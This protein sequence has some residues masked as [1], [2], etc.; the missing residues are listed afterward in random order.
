MAKVGSTKT[1]TEILETAGAMSSDPWWHGFAY[2]AIVCAFLSI[3]ALSLV[4][5]LSILVN[6]AESGSSDIPPKKKQEV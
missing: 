5:D 3:F 1:M 2:G 6:D 4:R